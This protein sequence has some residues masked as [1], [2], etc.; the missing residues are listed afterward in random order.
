VAALEVR[1]LSVGFPRAGGQVL[2]VVAGVSFSL[3]AGKVLGLAG[4]SGCGKSTATLAAMGYQAPRARIMSGQALLDGENLLAMRPAQRRSVWGRRIAY[5]S[6]NATQALNPGTT[7]GRQL[8]QHLRAHQHLSGD[9][10]HDRCVTLLRQM[11]IP[12]PEHALTRFP[13][14]FS[15]GQQQ[16][17]ALA[18]ALSCRPSVLL[19]DEP[20]TGLDVTTQAEITELLCELVA[21]SEV[22]VLYVSHD[23]AL[24]AGI[25]DELAV[26]Y[27]GQI[28]EHGAASDVVRRPRHPYTRALF[29][30]APRMDSAHLLP[31]IPG[32]PPQAAVL[33][34]CAFAERCPHATERCRAEHPWL[35]DVGGGHLASCLRVRELEHRS[36]RPRVVEA[37]GPLS[38]SARLLELSHVSFA[39]TRST[40]PALEDVSLDVEPGHQ[41]GIVG[42]SGSGKSTLLRVIAGLAAPMSGNLTFRDR[43]LPPSVTDRPLVTRQAIQLIFQNPASSLNPRHTVESILRR[44]LRMF[45]D[46]VAR[47][48]EKET[49]EQL[50]DQVRLPASLTQRFP[51]ELSGGQQQRVALARAFAAQPALLLCDEVT[52]ALDVSVQATVLELLAELSAQFG[53]AV[54]FAG[55]DLA[56]IRAIADDV[57]VMRHGRILESASTPRLFDAPVHPYTRELMAA[58]PSLPAVE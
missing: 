7:V 19:L 6:Q 3:R 18:I 50:L 58:V 2:P 20:T 13:F 57:L 30:L 38:P 14:E 45:R 21:A 27:A 34:R 17:V 11:G 43:P 1:D 46:D 40:A 24:L 23:L 39:Y 28:V 54:L 32:R 47:S 37:A 44:P 16:R 29:D 36:P 9:S 49:I 33:D 4:E 48:Q 53:V 8:R 56:V 35:E 52:S 5:V 55:H 22:A 10:L 42:E 26:M 41:L 51:G 12:D 15:G 31:G 25:A